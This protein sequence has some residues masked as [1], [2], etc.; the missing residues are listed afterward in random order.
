MTDE[1]TIAARMELASTEGIFVEPASAVPLAALKKLTG[2][3]Q[4]DATVVCICTGNGLKDQESVKVQ[5]DS[6]P[7]VA[8]PQQLVNLL[9]KTA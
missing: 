9:A 4:K 8:T 1:E 2:R 5:L 6:T 7:L 3:I